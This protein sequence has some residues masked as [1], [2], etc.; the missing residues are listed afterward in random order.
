VGDLGPALEEAYFSIYKIRLTHGKRF[1]DPGN[2]LEPN[3]FQRTG[4]IF[5]FGHQPFAPFFAQEAAAGEHAGYLNEIGLRGNVPHLVHL[6]FIDVAV[7]DQFEQVFKSE[8]IQLFF[9]QVGP[10]RAYTFQVLNGIG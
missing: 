10:L 8:D 9:E 5:Y 3:K 4:G 1:L 6:G 2:A 7:G